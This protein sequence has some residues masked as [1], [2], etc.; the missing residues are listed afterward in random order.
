MTCA[1]RQGSLPSISQ[2]MVR[3]PSVALLLHIGLGH[4]SYMC[5]PTHVASVCLLTLVTSVNEASVPSS[6]FAIPCPCDGF[7]TC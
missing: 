1:E 5:S 2:S 3:A 6:H 7:V 4:H